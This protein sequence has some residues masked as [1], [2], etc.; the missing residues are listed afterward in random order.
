M[1]GKLEPQLDPL[2]LLAQPAISPVERKDEDVGLGLEPTKS[3]SPLEL[4]FTHE[5]FPREERK[6]KDFEVVRG[7]I[8]AVCGN[9]TIG[10]TK[11]T[12][13]QYP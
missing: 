8:S 2:R 12:R 4:A 5:R 13:V 10:W 3:L 11:D 7:I 9:Q 6:K 1:F